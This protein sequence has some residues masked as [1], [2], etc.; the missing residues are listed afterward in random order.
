[1]SSKALADSHRIIIKV[2]SA[3]IA[4]ADTARV[5]YYWLAGLAKDIVDLQKQ[6]KEVC[7]VSS[8][9]VTL[10]YRSLGLQRDRLSHVEKQA[11]AACGQMIMMEAWQ[12]VFN[13]DEVRVAQ[14]LLTLDDSEIRKR[15]LNARN[16]LNT[17]IDNDIIPIINENDTVATTQLRVGDNDRLAARVAQMIGADMLILLSD[18]DGFYTA[19]P[20]KDSDAQFIPVINNI[21]D[22]IRASAAPPSTVVGTG[23]MVTKVDAATIA[24]N[25]GCH[26]MIGLGKTHRPVSALLEGARNTLFTAQTTPVSARKEWI[27]GV[28]SPCGVLFIDDGAISA[29][30]RGNSLLPV[31]VV[32][33]SGHFQRGDAVLIKRQ[34]SDVAVAKGLVCYNSEE[35]ERIIG[36][37]SH[38]ILQT[39]GYERGDAAVHRDD[40]VFM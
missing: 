18:I 23:G 15:Y 21:T 36:Q 13:E 5:N 34:G 37:Q 27:A 22:E 4:H 17:L 3:L 25:S 38:Q 32:D 14:V 28:L 11:A 29:L 7:V 39:L 16:T 30:Q 20:S 33:V 31:G 9:G 6:G 40:M 1:M 10:G 26:T 12:E 24:T 19:D 35:M 8:G 2:G